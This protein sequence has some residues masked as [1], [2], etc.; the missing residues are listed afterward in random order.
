MNVRLLAVAICLTPSLA[1][2]ICPVRSDIETGIIVTYDN[3][4][5]DSVL[6]LNVEGSVVELPLN[7]D[8]DGEKY[9]YILKDG[10]FETE[11]FIATKQS[12]SVDFLTAYEGKI[13]AILPLQPQSRSAMNVN[14]IYPSDEGYKPKGYK[15][16][17]GEFGISEH[18][19]LTT[20]PLSTTTIGGCTYDS[21][22]LL[23]EYTSPADEKN[24]LRQ[25]YLPDLGIAIYLGY[26]DSD[27]TSET[28]AAQTIYSLRK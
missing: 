11:S 1:A 23:F 5:F 9:G 27:G 7:F 28:A 6:T 4:L 20:G 17:A 18:M 12:R 16:S 25:T 8:E 19:V 21:F 10:I 13:N 24:D 22:S 2:A 14:Y 26:A 3:D 15:Y